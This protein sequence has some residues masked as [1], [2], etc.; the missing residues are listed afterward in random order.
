M[1]M[2]LTLRALNVGAISPRRRRKYAPQCELKSRSGSDEKPNV[3]LEIR[4]KFVLSGGRRYRTL[5]DTA[6]TVRLLNSCARHVTS[7]G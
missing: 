6:V 7:R 5:R 3:G 2:C 1:R 4:L